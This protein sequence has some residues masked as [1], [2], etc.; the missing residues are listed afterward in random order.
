MFLYVAMEQMY[1]IRIYGEVY[2]EENWTV[3]RMLI[4]YLNNSIGWA[5]IERF[6]AMKNGRGAFCN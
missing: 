3:F 4:E 1:Q 2:S 5:W 6:N